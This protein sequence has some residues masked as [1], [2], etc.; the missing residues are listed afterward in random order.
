MGRGY[1]TGGARASRRRIRRRGA[2]TG[3]P[4]SCL[5]WGRIAAPMR[6]P[7]PTG[8]SVGRAD[9]PQAA[10]VVLDRGRCAAGRTERVRVKGVL[11]QV[12]QAGVVEHGS[13]S[14]VD[15]RG[16]GGPKAQSDA[17]TLPHPAR[18]VRC[19]PDVDEVAVRGRSAAGQPARCSGRMSAGVGVPSR[20]SAISNS[21]REDREGPFDAGLAAGRERPQDRPADEDAARAE[22]ERDGDVE[23]APHAAVD[24]D[25]G[26]A[27]DGLDDLV[28]H[29]DRRRHAIELPRP[30]VA[31]R[32]SPSTPCSTARRASS[33]VRMP[34]ST[35]GQRRP[36]P[37]RRDVVPGEARSRPA[38]R[39]PPD[40]PLSSGR[41]WARRPREVAEAGQVEA[42]S[43]I[44][45]AVAHDRQ[46]DG[47]DDGPVAGRRGPFDQRPR[48]LAIL[49]QV[50]LEPADRVG[51]R[52]GHLLDRA[53]GH[54]RQRER[55]AG[56]GRRADG[57]QLGVGMRQL[58]DG[59][60]RDRERDGGRSTEPSSSRARPARR[61]PARAAGSDGAARPPRSRRG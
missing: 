43:P 3:R 25:L 13:T 16:T 36:R 39:L 11:D 37:D 41:G 42:G 34:L 6:A 17:S 26:P 28:E 55:H 50:Q 48:H 38:P 10:V 35:S 46:V 23:A 31:R 40:R 12:E 29:V 14:R 30:V 5:R 4:R 2:P 49:L 15:Q 56:R 21:S 51:R 52:L 58:V 9:E 1:R 47:Q 57:C 45:L 24:P 32:R 54:R 8:S 27:G 59:H 7:T 61:R 53:R 22:R 33:A 19:R 18:A 20:A 44:A 60:R